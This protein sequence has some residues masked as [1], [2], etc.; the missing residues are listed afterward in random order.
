MD[1]SSIRLVN[2]AAILVQAFPNSSSGDNVVITIRDI[3]DATNDVSQ[4]S[5][6]YDSGVSWKYSW[7]P[8]DAHLFQIDYWNATLDVHYYEYALVGGTPSASLVG[9]GSGST[10]T[11]LRTK[12]LKLIDNYNANDLTGTNS[13]GEI[14]DL[15]L[16]D[17]LQ[18][19]YSR[20]KASRYLQA[21]G[22]TSLASVVDQAYINLSGIADLDEIV[23]MKD[24]TND[25]VLYGFPA[26]RY[27][28][29]VPDPSASTGTPY[30]FCRIFNRVYL[31]PRP[32][33]AITYTTEY[34]KVYP[35]LSSGSDQALIPSKFDDW[36]MKEAR[37]IWWMMEEPRDIPPII[38]KERDEAR[39]IYEGD[40][41]SNTH[42]TLQSS[43]YFSRGARPG[44][45]PFNHI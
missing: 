40:A 31:D 21:Y 6:T 22:S 20:L 14:A 7:T 25:V 11:V 44:V 12:F 27:F 43:S 24:T 39:E 2:V 15:C 16:N 29:E 30:R 35:A 36:I 33:A 9:S 18:L 10:L 3:D 45:N 5:M 42:M 28:R 37:V 19:I 1:R 23:S 13:S 4:A 38:V 34:I 32:T 26:E 17:A 41:L 8:T